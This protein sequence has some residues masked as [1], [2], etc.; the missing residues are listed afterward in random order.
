[1][2]ARETDG[3]VKC[4]GSGEYG[5]GSQGGDR[6]TPTL[7]D[8]GIL[9]STLFG[10]PNTGTTCGLSVAGRAYCWGDGRFG[11]LGNNAALS[12]AQPVLVKLAR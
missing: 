3:S 2:C 11:E 5:A 1:M 6:L 4:W 9:F 7:L 8:G 12:S 10:S